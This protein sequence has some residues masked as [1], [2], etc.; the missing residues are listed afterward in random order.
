MGCFSELGQEKFIELSTAFYK[1]VY[2]DVEHPEFRKQFDSRPIAAA[3]K[4][5]YEF[6]IQRLGGPEIYSQNRA[7]DKYGGH[8]AL[9]ARHGM[10]A[11]TTAN[12]DNHMNLAL[13][14]VNIQGD[15]R[16]AMWQFF[17]HVAYFL[18]NRKD[19]E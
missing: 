1:R 13:D 8:P 5:Q 15:I 12:A 9:R 16:E 6:L 10:F 2:S 11:V 17:K 14:D 7:S 3:I 4:N 18:R 19:P